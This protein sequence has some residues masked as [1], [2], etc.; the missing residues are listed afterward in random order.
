MQIVSFKKDSSI[1]LENGCGLCLGHFDGVHIGHRAL[2]DELKRLN[3][4][5]DTKLPL[6]ALCFTTPPTLTLQRAPTPQLTTLDQKLQLLAEAGLDFAVLYDFPRLKDMPPDDFIRRVLM[7][8][9][10]AKMLVCGFNYSFGAKGAGKPID[11]EN[12]F[13][14]QPGRELSVVAPVTLGTH[15]VSS[16]LVR[17]MLQNGHPE[18]A[19]QLL[20]RPYTLVG[21]VEKGNQ[22]GRKMGLPTANLAFERDALV[23]LHGVYAVTVK[24]DNRTYT[25]ISNIG[26][27]PTVSRGSSVNCETFI[28]D[29]KG[30]LYGRSIKISFLHF[31]REERK[32][33]S[34]D[35]LEAQIRE[36][37]LRTKAMFL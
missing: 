16:T 32:F 5:R 24:I 19:T 21:T 31:L 7:L 34:L 35:A 1:S 33:P 30:N 27:R 4:R 6:G 3:N 20:G 37:I 23:P 28:F 15:T 18:M 13:A 17:S 11:L 26:T 25:G 36:D 2:I 10:N 9:C 8:D 22:I 14:T 29:Y 12:K